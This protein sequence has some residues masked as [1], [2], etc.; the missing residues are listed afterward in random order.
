[1]RVLADSHSIYWYLTDPDQLTD[2][3][4]EALG[5]A[6]ETGG[7]VVSAWSVPELWMAS[8]RKRGARSITGASYELVRAV[9]VD[10][11]IAVDVEPFGPAMWPHFETV[12][13]VLADPFDSA[14]V[15]TALALG[16]EV[17]T[18]DRAITDSATVG[19][20]W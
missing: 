18:R 2:R 1:V 15:A 14:I 12:S 17:V 20:I 11:E 19:V 6:E 5:E 10:P 4:L 7:V 3:A 13:T 16:L 8:T 9:L